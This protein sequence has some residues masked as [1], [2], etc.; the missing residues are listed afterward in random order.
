MIVAD[1]DVLIDALRGRSPVAE[2]I[3]LELQAGSL[4]TTAITAF[5]LRS[6]ARSARATAQVE[7]LLAALPILPLDE[8]A[9]E[10]A[11]GV[12]LDLETAGTPIGMAAYLIAGICL[13]RSA[14]LLTRNR[15]HFERVSGLTLGTWPG[16]GNA[17]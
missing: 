2:R 1:S 14:V 3:D 16:G 15:G 12:R 7:T 6:G 11:G 8:E 10:K 4:V 5:E 17:S 9:A 13:A